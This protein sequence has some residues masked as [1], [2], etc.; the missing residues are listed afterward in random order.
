MIRVPLLLIGAVSLLSSACTTTGNYAELEPQLT[1]W[2]ED[3]E[4]GRALKALGKVDP[5]DPNYNKSAKLRKQ[6]EKRA[7]E[8]EQQVRRETAKKV[9]KGDWAGALDQYDEALSRLPNSVVIRDG[10]AKLH[11]QQRDTIEQLELQR[12]IQHGEWLRDVIPVYHDITRVDPRSATAQ[13]RLGRINAEARDIAGELALAGNKALA[14]NDLGTAD[15]TLPLA[16]VLHNDPV[17]EESLNS[18]RTQQQ[19]RASKKRAEKRKR[20]QQARALKERRQHTITTLLKRYDAAF[21]KQDFE[22]ARKQLVKLEKVDKRYSK[23]ASMKKSLQQAIDTR[24][25][26]LFDSGVSAYSRGQFEQAAGKWR[27]ALKLDPNHQPSQENLQRAE[28]VLQNI[29]RLKEKQG[30]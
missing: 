7:A 26:R 29:Q 30:E 8:Y 2:E 19:K 11:Q 21:A 10:L 1:Q 18:L 20:D 15:R 12:L 24:V 23:L 4:Y 13:S 9:K 22:S 6:L 3:R 27:E 17:I 16:F 25:S 5:A 14:D 28:K